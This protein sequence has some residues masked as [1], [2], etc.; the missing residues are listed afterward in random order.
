MIHFVFL[1]LKY[2][3]YLFLSGIVSVLLRANVFVRDWLG[4]PI[5]VFMKL[6]A[7]WSDL[8]FVW[9]VNVYMFVCLFV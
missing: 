9:K 5:G 8:F 2:F 6:K 4:T 3:F 1:K 7:L